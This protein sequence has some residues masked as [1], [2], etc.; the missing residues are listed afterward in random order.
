[1]AE[2]NRGDQQL[3]LQKY[4]GM[5]AYPPSPDLLPGISPV[6]SLEQLPEELRFL[7]QEAVW[8]AHEESA[9]GVGTYAAI[10]GRNPAASGWLIVVDSIIISTDTAGI[11]SVVVQTASTSAPSVNQQAY[12]DTRWIA[13]VG[14]D[15]GA[16]IPGDAVAAAV[17]TGRVIW[18]HYVPANTPVSVLAAPYI[19]APTIGTTRLGSIGVYHNT[20][21][22]PI[23]RATFSGRQRTLYETE[24]G[25]LK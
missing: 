1:M 15:R 12:R 23:L 2:V 3:L 19:M 13:N 16:F 10:V 8:Q 14:A 18:E 7:R 21:A 4:F 25:I 9:A 6:I 11:V 24:D 5:N 17:P 20:I 22:T